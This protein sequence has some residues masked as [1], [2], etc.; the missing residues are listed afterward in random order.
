L[1]NKI[2]VGS[3]V[4]L[5]NDLFIAMQG[6]CWGDKIDGAQHCTTRIHGWL[7]YEWHLSCNLE[8]KD[9]KI[10]EISYPNVSKS[11]GC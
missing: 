8:L 1:L 2:P 5:A 11:H 3:E 7:L 6:K 4:K 9:G 10:I